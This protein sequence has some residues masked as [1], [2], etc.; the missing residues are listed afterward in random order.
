MRK[1]TPNL[2]T[3]KQDIEEGETIVEIEIPSYKIVRSN[4][5]FQPWGKKKLIYALFKETR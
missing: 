4:I 1:P 3:A 5:K 2:G